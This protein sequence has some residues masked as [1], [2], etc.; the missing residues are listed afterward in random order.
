MAAYWLVPMGRSFSTASPAQARV[1]TG[2]SSSP[3]RLSS[4]L[5]ER[6]TLHWHRAS[7]TMPMT[8]K[9][10]QWESFRMRWRVASS[11]RDSTASHTSM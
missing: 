7:S 5:P 11:R 2:I 1:A 3:H 10:P 4:A 6:N 9:A 8:A